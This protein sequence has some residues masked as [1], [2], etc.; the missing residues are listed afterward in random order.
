VDWLSPYGVPGR[1]SAGVTALVTAV[2]VAIKGVYAAVVVLLVIA[3]LS[4]LSAWHYART[5]PER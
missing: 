2:I 3:A 1:V 5:H 4:F